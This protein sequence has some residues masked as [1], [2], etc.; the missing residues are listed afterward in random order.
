MIFDGKVHVAP[1]PRDSDSVG[2]LAVAGSRG[3]D[4]AH[5]PGSERDLSHTNSDPA[6]ANP[7]AKAKSVGRGNSSSAHPA[8]G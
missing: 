8:A 7:K 6:H 3:G 4:P 5:L 1:N 2:A